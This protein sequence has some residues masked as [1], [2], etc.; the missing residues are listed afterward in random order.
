LPDSLETIG[1]QALYDLGEIELVSDYLPKNLKTVDQYFLNSCKLKNNVLYFPQGFTSLAARYC[2]AGSFEPETSLTLVFLGKMTSVNLSDT[3]LT[4]FLDKGSRKPIKLV[5][6]QNEH[7]DLSGPIV[8]TVDFN[9]QKGFIAISKDGSSLY[10]NQEGTLTVSFENA[11]YYN[12][13][14][15]GA[16]ANG[17]T[18]HSVGN[19]PTEI[20]FCGGD[21]VEISY[22]IRC[23]H[24]DKGWYRFHT[25]SEVYDMST[26][27]ID[28]VHYNKYV[29]QQGNCGYDET[30]TNTCV[31][32]KLQSVVVGEKATGDHTYVDD[33]NC[34]TA[35]NCEV[36]L[37]TLK[38]AL[39]HDIKTT[40]LYEKGYTAEGLK[41]V[42]CQNE[43]C[44]HSEGEEKTNALFTCLGYSAPEDGRGGITIGFK[45]NNVAIKD[46]V[47]ITGKTLKYGVFAASL[48]K[49]QDDY[50][51]EN[52]VA[53]ENAICAEI[54]ATEF[55]AFD[56]KIT[57]FTEEQKDTKLAIGAY[58]AVTDGE[59]IDF[60]YLQDDSKGITNGKY[61]FISYNE[62]IK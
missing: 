12:L 39:A 19:S 22:T 4:T 26:H 59:K 32:C 18:I 25:T 48:E 17:N 13:T 60:T 57:G 56:L 21:S 55:S 51:F 20:I 30:I 45:V 23:N 34:E 41:T 62:I 28:G 53:N 49:L 33:F 15:I 42:A 40:V 29:Y 14:G 24:T 61:Y 9:G 5:F 36:C 43:G 31:I 27:E 38:E 6:A 10:T 37:K 50:I 44:S 58:V 52:G 54:K 7:S 35:L 3:S 47:E 11:N 16:D 8:P 2:F 1:F 46:Y